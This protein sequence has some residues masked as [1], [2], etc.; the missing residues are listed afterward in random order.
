MCVCVSLYASMHVCMHVFI[1]THTEV[2]RYMHTGSTAARCHVCLL[3]AWVFLRT[4][5]PIPQAQKA[6]TR[7][8]TQPYTV[9]LKASCA[10]HVRAS[11][12]EVPMS[13][14]RA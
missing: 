1:A 10:G 5:N 2:S 11:F 6:S 14:A 9:N 4:L 3:S 13:W 12:D 7:N 8:P